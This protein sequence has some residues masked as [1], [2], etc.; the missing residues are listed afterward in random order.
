MCKAVFAVFSMY[1]RVS[2]S[3][4]VKKFCYIL[5]NIFQNGFNPM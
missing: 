4:K 1:F 5:L 3:L 2:E